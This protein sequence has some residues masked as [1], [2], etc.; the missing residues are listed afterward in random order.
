MT[1]KEG[2]GAPDHT[3]LEGGGPAHNTTL[4]V[5]DGRL[6]GADQTSD[7]G[8]RLRGSGGELPEGSH[9]SRETPQGIYDSVWVDEVLDKALAVRLS[10]NV[11]LPTD[12]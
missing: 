10:M 1:S 5:P 2:A 6:P 11:P 9:R 12:H 8:L 4:D 3:S 7:K